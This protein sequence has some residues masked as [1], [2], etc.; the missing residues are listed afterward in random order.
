VVFGLC[1]LSVYLYRR[2]QRML[3]EKEEEIETLRNMLASADKSDDRFRNNRCIFKF[4]FGIIY[5]K[6]VISA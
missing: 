5:F 2:R 4:I 1:L 6:L 3:L